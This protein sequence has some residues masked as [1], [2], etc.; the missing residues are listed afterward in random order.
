M[1]RE[2]ELMTLGPVDDDVDSLHVEKN[3]VNDF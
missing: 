2:I 3:R 1:L